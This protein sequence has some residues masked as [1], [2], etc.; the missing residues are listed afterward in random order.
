V[1]KVLLPAV[2]AAVALGLAT[3]SP[4]R[5]QAPRFRPIVIPSLAAQSINPNPVIAPGL[6]LQQYAYNT[7]VMGRALATV[8]PYALGY[9]PYPAVVNYGPV[10]GNYGNPYVNPYVSPYLSTP[11]NYYSSY[12]SGSPYYP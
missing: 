11:I 6:T 7:A 3:A 5:A 1:R 9:N 10:I 12:L 4:A 8:P 2:V